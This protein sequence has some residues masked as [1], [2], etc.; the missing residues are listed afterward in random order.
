MHRELSQNFK[1]SLLFAHGYQWLSL[2]TTWLSMVIGNLMF[3]AYFEVYYLILMKDGLK[4]LKVHH[5]LPLV[6]IRCP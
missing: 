6:T 2:A 3:K 1:G 5:W 4:S